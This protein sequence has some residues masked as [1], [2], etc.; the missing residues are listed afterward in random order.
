MELHAFFLNFYPT[1]LSKWNILIDYVM[2]LGTFLERYAKERYNID[3]MVESY[4]P[5]YNPKT[6]LE[7]REYDLKSH[8]YFQKQLQ[9]YVVYDIDFNHPEWGAASGACDIERIGPTI[10]PKDMLYVEMSKFTGL[11]SVIPTIYDFYSE[12]SR[13][14]THELDHRFLAYMSD[15]QWIHKVHKAQAV[16]HPPMNK[17]LVRWEMPDGSFF[18]SQA[19]P[20]G[21]T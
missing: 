3:L 13:A 19:S 5:A 7:L 11:P 8:E 16:H 1:A 20:L 6:Y 17:P 15:D 2:K 10:S 14:V 12:F 9:M 18:F 21:F 4:W